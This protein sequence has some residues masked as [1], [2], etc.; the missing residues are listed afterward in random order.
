MRSILGASRSPGPLEGPLALPSTKLAQRCDFV[1][2]L[3]LARL[4]SLAGGTGSAPEAFLRA[5]PSVPTGLSA[6]SISSTSATLNGAPSSVASGCSV[7]SYTVYENATSLGA[8]TSTSF[9]VPGLLPSTPQAPEIYNFQIAA[10]DA[11]AISSPSGAVSVTTVQAP[12]Y[13]VNV[14]RVSGSLTYS[15]TVTLIVPP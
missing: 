11:A 14:T 12:T 6:S 7:S 1:G 10:S 3:L 9:A 4:L 8:P 2:G 15:S 5:A 13:T